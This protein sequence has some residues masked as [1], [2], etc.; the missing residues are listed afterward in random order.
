VPV[1]LDRQIRYF[2]MQRDRSPNAKFWLPLADLHL[3]N[4]EADRA[5][6]LLEA[7]DVAASGAASARWVLARAQAELGDMDSARRSL[8]AVLDLDPDHRG[9]PDLL[10]SLD[11]RVADTA[12]PVAEVTAAAPAAAAVPEPAPTPGVV[13]EPPIDQDV[14]LGPEASATVEASAPQ[15]PPVHEPPTIEAAPAEPDQG[16]EAAHAETPA[17]AD[18]APNVFLTRTLA[19]IYLAQGHKDKALEILYKVLSDHPDR[20]DVVAQIAAVES[21]EPKA[22]AEAAPPPPTAAAPD[23]D[24][25]PAAEP[26]GPPPAAEKED[27]NRK[28]FEE[29][30]AREREAGGES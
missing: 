7:N 6:E 26:S 22:P 15:A 19:D 14:P 1:N 30:L 29:W 27:A 16:P 9:A 28:R 24:R 13:E 11:R 10:Q 17:T 8:A 3:R 2:E 12:P 25:T 23:P 21:D 18:A 5:L 20:D 4:G